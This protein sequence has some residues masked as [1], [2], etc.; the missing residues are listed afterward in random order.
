MARA[1]RYQV[2]DGKLV[3]ILQ[4]EEKGWYSVTA[5]GHP[6]VNTQARSIQEAFR[7][8]RDAMAALA[9]SRRDLRRFEKAP[10]RL[11]RTG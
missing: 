11:R 5:P 6:G 9:E 7:M 3:L 2:S 10:R 1:N 4:E 8:A